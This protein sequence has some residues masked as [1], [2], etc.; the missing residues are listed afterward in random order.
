[1][2]YAHLNLSEFYSNIAIFRPIALGRT[3]REAFGMAA[4]AIECVFGVGGFGSVVILW[5]QYAVTHFC[6]KGN[7]EK[8]I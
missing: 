7:Y 8:R 3:K 6:P 4:D 5:L 1:M 2:A